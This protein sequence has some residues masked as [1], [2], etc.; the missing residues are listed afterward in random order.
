MEQ[1]RGYVTQ[2][3]LK[4]VVYKRLYMD[5]S[6][7]QGRGLRISTSPFLVL[8]FADIIQIILSSFGAQDLPYSSG[9]LC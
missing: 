5:S 8:A 2:G 6:R 1:P 4:S 3:K 9:H 7:V